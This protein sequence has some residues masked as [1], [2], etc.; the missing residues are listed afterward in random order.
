MKKYTQFITEST[1]YME[2]VRQHVNQKYKVKELE[3]SNNRFDFQLLNL[4][5]II[6]FEVLWGA[7]GFELY[8]FVE[9][10]GGFQKMLYSG[11]QRKLNDVLYMIGIEADYFIKQYSK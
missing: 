10:D 9:E 4:K 8:V 5:K 3:F 2:L 1:T 6:T 11:K 7:F